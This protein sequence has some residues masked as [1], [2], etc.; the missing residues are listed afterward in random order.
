MKIKKIK[1]TIPSIG[2]KKKVE[3]LYLVGATGCAGKRETCPH[4]AKSTIR[5]QTDWKNEIEEE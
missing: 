4:Q 3:Q 2:I 5:P 1:I